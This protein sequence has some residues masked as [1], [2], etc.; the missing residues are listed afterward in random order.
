MH[1][2]AVGQFISVHT[3]ELFR[4]GD[5]DTRVRTPGQLLTF[6]SNRMQLRARR[7]ILDAQEETCHK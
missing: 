3:R 5:L 7:P 6:A 4:G 1:Q 2:V